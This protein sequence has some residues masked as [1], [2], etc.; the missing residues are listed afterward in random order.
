MLERKIS[1]RSERKVSRPGGQLERKTSDK[2]EAAGPV[3]KKISKIEKKESVVS[4]S[5]NVP[6][7]KKVSSRQDVVVK[8]DSR[9]EVP[10]IV[11]EE[12][13][14]ANQDRREW[15]VVTKNN[16][17]IV[18]SDDDDNEDDIDND[19]VEDEVENVFN[20][21]KTRKS[22]QPPPVMKSVEIINKDSS[23][24][25]SQR[26]QSFLNP[27]EPPCPELVNKSKLIEEF[28]TVQEQNLKN[29]IKDLEEPLMKESLSHIEPSNQTYFTSQALNNATSSTINQVK[30]FC[31]SYLKP[32]EV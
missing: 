20:A 13:A 25:N 9:A 29:N 6:P 17:A 28:N 19:S 10:V 27:F 14:Q 24:I 16:D 23:E 5:K 4:I 8:K 30:S 32:C 3:V 18:R 7:L 22:S 1:E 2:V 21:N 26:K 15:K 31:L 12:S 11:S